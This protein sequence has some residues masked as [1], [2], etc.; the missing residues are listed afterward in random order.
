MN[1]EVIGIATFQ[2]I[3]GQNLNFAIPSERIA[4]L[5]L[6]EEEKTFTTEELFEQEDKD[7]K[8]SDYSEAYNKAL[9]FMDK[10]EYEKALPYLEIAINTDISPLK[11]QAYFKIGFCY[12]KLKSYVKAIEAFRQV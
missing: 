11:A 10:E 5:N 1:G 12:V 8:I 3:E 9:Y 4:S 2:F 6:M 7:K